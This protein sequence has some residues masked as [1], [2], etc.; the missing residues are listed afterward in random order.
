M[1]LEVKPVWTPL[2]AVTDTMQI[3]KSFNVLGV[4]LLH[5]KPAAQLVGALSA[6]SAPR[7]ISPLTA[8][9]APLNALDQTRNQMPMVDVSA[10]TA[11]SPTALEH[12][13]P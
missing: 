1:N 2:L 4:V 10:W 12:V 13:S 9:R 3:Q 7:G 11:S 5:A 8:L 6:Q